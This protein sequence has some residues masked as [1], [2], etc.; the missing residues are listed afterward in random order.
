MFNISLLGDTCID[1]YIYGTVTRLNPE[2]PCPVL[3]TTHIVEKKGMA[4]NVKNN[5]KNLGCKVNLYTSKVPSILTRYVETQFNTQYLRV[6]DIKEST[7]LNINNIDLNVDAIVI[8]DYNKGTISEDLLS[9][10]RKLYH[11]PIFLDTSKK[12]IPI[13]NLII[14]I[15]KKESIGFTSLSKD[16]IIT[17]GSEG[18]LYQNKTF[19]P[20]NTNLIDP[21][22][23]GDTFLA[24]L[25][26]N[27]LQTKDLCKS[28]EFA[29]IAS[30]I[31][32]ENIG[33]YAP[34]LSEIKGYINGNN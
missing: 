3:N 4:F 25:C 9:K 2:Y 7:E 34:K 14:K 20:R 29:N 21:C 10:I 17:L 31:T 28:I 12:N 32:V 15:N 11:G 13:E 33:V 30:S 16:I 18:A 24:S 23:A 1:R 6:D 5:L 8:S 26:Y 27:Y 22:G 19:K